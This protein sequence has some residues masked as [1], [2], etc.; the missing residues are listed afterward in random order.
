MIV[1]YPVTFDDVKNAKIIFGP[2][3]TL[4][5]GKSMR[6]KPAGVVTDSVGIP[7]EILKSRKE[8]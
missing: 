3:I 2:D 6:R 5:K 4:L 1:N 8:L 7:R